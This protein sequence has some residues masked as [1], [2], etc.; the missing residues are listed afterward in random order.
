MGNPNIGGAGDGIGPSCN[1]TTRSQPAVEADVI[2]RNQLERLARRRWV[3]GMASRI[4]K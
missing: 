4:N 3:V 2:E 1:R